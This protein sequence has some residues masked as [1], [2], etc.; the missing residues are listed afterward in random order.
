MDKPDPS[1]RDP[2]REF[3]K[4]THSLQSFLAEGSW[5]V[6]NL[7]RL[8]RATLTNRV[9]GQ[10]REKLLLAVTTAND[11][12]YCVQ[13]HGSVAGIVGIDD[14]TIGRIQDADI[15]A[16]VSEA[17]QPALLFGLQYAETDGHPTPDMLAALEAAYDPT[18]V[19]D[20]VAFTRAMHFANL[21]GN[22]V[23]VG[24]FAIEHRLARG[25]G[26]ARERCPL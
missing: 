2:T 7:P 1:S 17:E 3:R 11:C 8:G 16:A 6:W 21:L 25:F 13:F 23:D 12:R 24:V 4:R 9:D 5:V 19:A 20:I 22:T 26:R 18:T 10:F 15:E 14:E